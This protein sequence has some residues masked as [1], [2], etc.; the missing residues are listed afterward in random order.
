VKQL[1]NGQPKGTGTLLL[2]GV[3][4]A[5]ILGAPLAGSA[6]VGSPFGVKAVDSE[7]QSTFAIAGLSK[8]K[9]GTVPSPGSSAEPTVPATP[10]PTAPPV[11]EPTTPP[12][13]TPP[14]TTPPAPSYPTPSPASY[15][16]FSRGSDGNA[17]VM[18]YTGPLASD[19]V[20]PQTAMISGGERPV[21]AIDKSIFQNKKLTSVVLP[22]TVSSIGIYA[23]S[24]N[25]LTSVKFPKGLKFVGANAFANNLITELELNQGLETIDTA[26][27]S[28]NRIASLNFP[29]SVSTIGTQAFL[30]N[31]L[32]S[33]KLPSSSMSMILNSSFGSNS[34]TSVVIP[35]NIT[36]IADGAFTSN[37]LTSVKLPS[38]LNSIERNA[39]SGNP[40]EEIRIPASVTFIGPTAFH[41][42]TTL[43]RIYMEGNAPATVTAGSSSSPG[44]FGPTATT[45]KVYYR[46]SATGY[47]NPW[48]GYAAEQ[49]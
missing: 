16:S 33:V 11:T 46:A 41:N 7:L 29:D 17:T 27:F 28:D 44:S 10:S 24:G 19:L 12:T 43:K 5:A 40:L 32:T 39:F 26:A 34:L 35:E 25:S 36:A 31:N 23:F 37:R 3:T 42:G 21:T 18:G 20:I 30:R 4:L 15:F 8:A 6:S 38:R 47:S 2:T 14:V 9:D 13:T 1:R 49:Y 48:K 22:D 45:K